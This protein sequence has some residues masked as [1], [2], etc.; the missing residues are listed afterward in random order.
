MTEGDFHAACLRLEEA[1]FDIREAVYHERA[2]GSWLIELSKPRRRLIWDGKD[3]IL[4]V[5]QRRML[6]GWTDLWVD[7]DEDRSI[8]AALRV[9]GLRF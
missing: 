4:A 9:M 5:Q 3:R 2:F 1:G 8:E 7:P 6:R